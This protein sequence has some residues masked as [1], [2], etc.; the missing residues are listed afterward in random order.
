MNLDPVKRF[1][2]SPHIKGWAD[3]MAS[4]QFQEAALA[5]I[6]QQSR[7]LETPDSQDSAAANFFRI[8][9]AQDFIANLMRL[10]ESA[11]EPPKPRSYNL[12]MKP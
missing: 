3:I 7:N 2:E 9:G 11:P 4:A 5:A 8:Q 6:W 10:G 12:N 1:R